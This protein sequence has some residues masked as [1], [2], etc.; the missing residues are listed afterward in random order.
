MI[1]D[2]AS[3]TNLLALNAAIEA[4]RAGEQGRGFAVVADEV[5]SLALRTQDSTTEIQTM[6]ET[7]SKGASQASN[8]IGQSRQ[9][10]QNS[11]QAMKQTSEQL[12]GILETV[13]SIHLVNAQVASAAE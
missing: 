5:R 11:T 6:L 2:I 13:S 3:Q 1:C 10:A 4:A 9:Q 7:L 12:M 8:L